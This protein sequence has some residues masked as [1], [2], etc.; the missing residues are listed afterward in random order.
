MLDHDL[1]SR[2]QSMV[3]GD[4]HVPFG[5]DMFLQYYH[6][7][8]VHLQMIDPVSSTSSKRASWNWPLWWFVGGDNNVQQLG[9][10]ISVY[11][12]LQEG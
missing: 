7:S 11:H 12:K 2:I 8:I 5:H 1:R 10:R 9:P 3:V 4:D 6:V